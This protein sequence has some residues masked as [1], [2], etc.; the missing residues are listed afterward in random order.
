MEHR[1]DMAARALDALGPQERQRFDERA[2]AAT[3][4][5]LADMQETAAALGGAVAVDPPASLRA[6]ILAR[7]AEVEQEPAVR[8]VHA[9]EES[10]SAAPAQGIDGIREPALVGGGSTIAGPRELAARRRWFQRPGSMLAAA[11]AA[12][13]LLVG[14]VAI[15]QGIRTPDPVSALVHASDVATQT[16]SFA[17]GTQAT[18][19]TSVERGEAALVFEGLES[20]DEQQVYEAWFMRDG[21]P[22][23]AGI[24]EGGEGS[25]VHVL[26][27]DMHE[28]D[29]VAI[30]IEPEGGS[31]QPTSN[32]LVV[33]EA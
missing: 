7:I 32:P 4:A 14:G 28:G 20:L 26:E 1:D 24:F 6:S 29:G 3:L 21:V 15:G 5:E 22:V 27:G 12:V 2:D 10:S 11:A 25:V 19:L 8:S 23:A 17:D 33:M 18:L 31:E 13:V 30:T 9:A 16:E